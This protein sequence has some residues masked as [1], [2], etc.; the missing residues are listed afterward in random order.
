MAELSAV[1]FSALPQASDGYTVLYENDQVCRS[2]KKLSELVGNKTSSFLT[3]EQGDSLYQEKGDY[4]VDDDITGKLDKEQYANDSATFLTAHQPLDEY[5][6]KDWVEEQNYITGVDLTNYY[7][8]SETSGAGELTEEFNK[9]LKI[10]TDVEESKQYTYST[11]G[12]SEIVNSE[13]YETETVTINHKSGWGDAP[14][15][16]VTANAGKLIYINQPSSI[17]TTDIQQIELTLN[18]VKNTNKPYFA[19][20]NATKILNLCSFIVKDE[21]GTYFTP[22]DCKSY[23]WL[24]GDGNSNNKVYLIEFLP[25][26]TFFAH[27]IGNADNTKFI[28]VTKN[29][30]KQYYD[31]VNLLSFD[32]YMPFIKTEQGLALFAY[33]TTGGNIVF[34]SSPNEN[35]EMQKITFVYNTFTV[36]TTTE[37]LGGGAGTSNSWKQLSEDYHS[38]G[39]LTDDKFCVYVGKYNTGFNDSYTMGRENYSEPGV[40][41]GYAN[42]INVE[43]LETL[44]GNFNFGKTNIISGNPGGVNLGQSNS[45]FSWGVNL[46][47]YNKGNL[48]GYNIGNSNKADN[49]SIN[50]GE[51]NSASLGSYNIGCN[52]TSDSAGYTFGYNNSANNASFSVGNYNKTIKASYAIGERNSAFEGSYTI[53]SS[54]SAE[55]GSFIFGKGNNVQGGGLAFGITTSSFAG[56]VFGNKITA[57]NG[58]VA[59]GSDITGT[60]GSVAIGAKNY[61][62]EGS[63]VIGNGNRANKGT[64]TIGDSNTATYTDIIGNRNAINNNV[65]NDSELSSEYYTKHINDYETTSI[66]INNFVAGLGNSADYAKNSFILGNTNKIIS[67]SADYINEDNDGYVFIYGWQNSADRNYDMAIGYKSFASGGENI[68]I[69]VPFETITGYNNYEGYFTTGPITPVAKG[70]KN[71]VLRGNVTGVANTAINSNLTGDYI[72]E[73][74]LGDVT[75][76]C[77][78]NSFVSATTT[79]I[80]DDNTF[81]GIMLNN[82]VRN[83]TVILSSVNI[84]ENQ[85]THTSN[86]KITGHDF[87]YNNLY[88]D[89]D[90]KLSGLNINNNTI[91]NCEKFNVSSQNI[92]SN[93]I[94]NCTAN[95]TVTANKLFADNIIGKAL[96]ATSCSSIQSVNENIIFNT[97]IDSKS[98]SAYRGWGD[99]NDSYTTLTRNFLFGSYIGNYVYG[100]FSFSDNS[101]TNSDGYKISN[102]CRVFNFG[103][104]IINK[105]ECSFVFGTKN[106]NSAINRTFVFGDSNNLQKTVLTSGSYDYISDLVVFGY[107]N[108]L[109]SDNSSISSKPIFER[110]RIFGTHNLIKANNHLNDNLIVGNCNRI[111]YNTTKPSKSTIREYVN[112]PSTSISSESAAFATYRNNIFGNGNRISQCIT[113]SLIVGVSNYVFDTIEHSPSQTADYNS[114]YTLGVGNIAY[115][116][117][118]QLNIG[119]NNETSGHFAEAIGD[120]IVAKGQQLIIGKCN[121][122]V[123]NTNRYSIEYDSVTDTIKNIEQSGVIFAIGNGTYDYAARIYDS[124]YIEYYD[125]NKNKIPSANVNNEEYITRSNALIVS[126]NGVV[127]ANDYY[128]AAGD[129]LSDLTEIVALLRN[130]PTTGTYGIK[131]IDGTLTW[132][133]E[134]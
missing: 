40:N 134:T 95:S 122:I 104:N 60:N 131:C 133:A 124:D 102:T 29:T 43:A 3:K 65:L 13:Q 22:A 42:K 2:E 41:I 83:S 99:S 103:D 47:E 67:D 76:N 113:D 56:F 114:I 111:S 8:K 119:Y 52:N 116:G 20:V 107:Q 27:R 78:I 75:N 53:G 84:R 121:A 44:P 37:V 98:V 68:A 21:N 106:I 130:K 10:P 54:N 71:F 14:L 26:K 91:I 30:G 73:N 82:T 89:K 109:I 92:C 125:K 105:A 48:G 97:Y 31:Y 80:N 12:W 19:Y 69:G 55:A 100:T 32:G 112:F 46:G 101:N 39:E 79:G 18:N 34:L 72:D 110:N 126:A 86:I 38:S 15:Y 49:A 132:V 50:I 1:P 87:N 64:T 66:Q 62:N 128:N 120:G 88:H 24:V 81:T 85:I 93:T 9:Y 74:K 7:T 4:L 17:P 25:N 6:T 33:K 129:K 16:E 51:R 5:A 94:F 23:C 45:A 96:F 123:D 115:D 61:A 36:K 11:T 28:E 127:S 35:G 118:N 90:L 108:N 63:F 58:S 117:S 59:I 57:D 70:Y 77:L